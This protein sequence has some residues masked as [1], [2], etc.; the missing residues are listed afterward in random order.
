M[1]KPLVSAAF[2]G[3]KVTCFAYG[4][5]GSGK[6]YTMLGPPNEGLEESRIP[7]L[8]LLASNDIF[9]LKKQVS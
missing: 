8:F 5:T 3:T 2:K 7:G 4:Q 9:L 6:T 1:V